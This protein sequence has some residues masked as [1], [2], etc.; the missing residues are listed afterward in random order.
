MGLN[1]VESCFELADAGEK[2]NSGS[3]GEVGGLAGQELV[4]GEA[5]DF[6]DVAKAALGA[7]AAE[8]L[9]FFGGDAEADH[10]AAGFELS[11]LQGFPALEGAAAVG[12]GLV[13]RRIEKGGFVRRPELL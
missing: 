10:S 2:G 7:E 11:F 9:E 1:E 6:G 13:R 8:A 4:D 3:V 5:D 12:A